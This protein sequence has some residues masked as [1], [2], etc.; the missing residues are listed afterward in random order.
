MQTA[1]A[2]LIHCTLLT[3]GFAPID[4]DDVAMYHRRQDDRTAV[5]CNDGLVGTWQ[6]GGSSRRLPLAAF[7]RTYC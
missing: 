4:A 5:I 7:E 3:A 2:T 6:A 1:H